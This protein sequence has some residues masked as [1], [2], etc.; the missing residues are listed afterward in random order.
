MGVVDTNDWCKILAGVKINIDLKAMSDNNKLKTNKSSRT[1]QS[2][3]P[4]DPWHLRSHGC[5]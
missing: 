2:S 5:C 1:V 3:Y 4:S